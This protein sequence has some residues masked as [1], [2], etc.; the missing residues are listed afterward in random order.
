MAC[1][2]VDMDIHG[3]DEE[4]LRANR[5]EPPMMRHYQA[6]ELLP[7]NKRPLHDLLQKQ[8]AV[9][10]VRMTKTLKK[11]ATRKPTLSF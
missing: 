9:L 3:T 7:D 1:A 10:G 8:P 4:L 6:L 5:R 2:D 11:Q